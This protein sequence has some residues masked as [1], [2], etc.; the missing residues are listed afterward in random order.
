MDTHAALSPM[1]LTIGGIV[2]AVAA[3]AFAAYKIYKHWAAVE[4]FFETLWTDIKKIFASAVTW[5]ESVR[6]NQSVGQRNPG[7][8]RVSDRSP[9]HYGEIHHRP[10]QGS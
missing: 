3:L 6:V 4:S 8:R 7:R 1:A 5:I 9:G 10:L 2:I